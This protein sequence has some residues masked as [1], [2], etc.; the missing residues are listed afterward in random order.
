M[1]KVEKKML[2]IVMDSA[3]DTVLSIHVTSKL[4]GTFASAEMASKELQAEYNVIPVDSGGGSASIGYMCKEAR[5]MFL[6]GFSI[7]K[8]LDRLIYIRD[9]T[10]II[11]TLDTLE[12]ARMSGRVKA[13]HA[14][15]ASSLM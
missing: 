14:A 3:G 5:E 2:R 6:K 9:H 11:L 10:E 15:L 8:I 13:M 1:E 12:Y 4:S 7:Q